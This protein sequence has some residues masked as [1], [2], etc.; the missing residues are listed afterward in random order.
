MDSSSISDDV[1]VAV[2]SASDKDQISR[3]KRQNSIYDFRTQKE[4]YIILL[5]V[6][7]ASLL[8]PFSDTIYLPALVS[9]TEDLNTTATLA[10]ASVAVFMFTVG[11]TALLW[12]LFAGLYVVLHTG[13]TRLAYQQ[14]TLSVLP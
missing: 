1:E 14:S 9:L 8:L 13:L 3:L 5:V 10:A 11:A 4:K 2:G 6:S 7:F 12:G